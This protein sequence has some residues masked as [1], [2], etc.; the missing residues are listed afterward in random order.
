MKILIH[1]DTPYQI[2]P[3]TSIVS[4]EVKW[5]KVEFSEIVEVCLTRDN[6]DYL[7]EVQDIKF[8]LHFIPS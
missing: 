2:E 8:S 7:L 3:D 4:G 1:F 5:I 6:V